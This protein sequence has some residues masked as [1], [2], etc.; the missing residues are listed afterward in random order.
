MKFEIDTTELNKE[1]RTSLA[2]LLFES[3]Y[4]VKLVKTKDGSKIKYIIACEKG[5]GT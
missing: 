4:S 2:M 3:G 5:A 1:K